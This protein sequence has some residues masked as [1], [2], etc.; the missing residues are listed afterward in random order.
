M[1]ALK[2]LT[3]ALGALALAGVGCG[4]DDGGDGNTNPNLDAST[5]SATLDSTVRSDASGDAS[6]FACKANTPA[7]ATMCGGSHC[8][9]T[10]A[11]LKASV[12]SGAA[13]SKTEELDQFCSLQSI[14]AVQMC[15]IQN[16]QKPEAERAAAVKACATPMLPAYTSGCLDCFVQSAVCAAKEC[17]TVCVADPGAAACDQCRVEKGCIPSFYTCAGIDNPIPGL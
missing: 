8:L 5:D 3:L 11:Q 14:G 16:Y 13:C 12:M 17:L 2:R 6:T 10:P 4:D 9:Q 1:K 7:T 15:I